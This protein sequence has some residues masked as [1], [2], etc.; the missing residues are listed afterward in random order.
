MISVV[1]PKCERA[2]SVLPLSPTGLLGSQCHR[3][4]VLG[5]VVV[6]EEDEPMGDGIAESGVE[7]TRL[8]SC[9]PELLDSLVLL[10]GSLNLL[11]LGDGLSW[12]VSSTVP[13]VEGPESKADEVVGRGTDMFVRSFEESLQ[14]S[15]AD[16]GRKRCRL[17]ARL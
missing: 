11:P 12:R 1:L 15:S 10:L 4:G 9:S 17:E 6:R 2:P 13:R 8:L 3:T 16:L 14:F 5:M 7:S